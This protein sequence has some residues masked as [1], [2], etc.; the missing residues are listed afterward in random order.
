MKT[1]VMEAELLK[2]KRAIDISK[3]VHS[4]GQDVTDGRIEIEAV[5]LLECWKVKIC[6]RN[7]TYPERKVEH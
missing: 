1:R 4:D 5:L 6:W 2:P 3:C 7:S